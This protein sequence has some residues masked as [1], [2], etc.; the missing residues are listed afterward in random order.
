MLLS[1]WCFS[2]GRR[3]VFLRSYHVRFQLSLPESFWKLVFYTDLG[4]N[5]VIMMI[6]SLSENS[7]L[8][9][10]TLPPTPNVL[11]QMGI[12]LLFLLKYL[13]LFYE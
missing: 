4:P 11:K 6:L 5:W 10:S 8:K 1:L 13:Q 7:N 12:Y 3:S 9:S 2:R